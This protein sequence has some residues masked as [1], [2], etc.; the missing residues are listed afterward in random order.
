MVLTTHQLLAPK[1]SYE[2]LFLYLPPSVPA[3][4]VTGQLF[5]GAF[6]QMQK[7]VMGFIM[8]VCPS[9]HMEQLGSHRTDFQEI[10]YFIFFENLLRN[11]VSLKSDKNYGNFT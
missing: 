11:Q 2:E 9:V 5:L 1:F 3:W 4:H 7:A 8:S 10:L 6:A